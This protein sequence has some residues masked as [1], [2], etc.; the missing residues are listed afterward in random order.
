MQPARQASKGKERSQ[1]GRLH[2]GVPAFFVIGLSQ[3]HQLGMQVQWVMPKLAQRS[4]G[5]FTRV[6]SAVSIGNCI[7]DT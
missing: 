4:Y 3:V 6:E 7:E 5:I 2:L 1:H